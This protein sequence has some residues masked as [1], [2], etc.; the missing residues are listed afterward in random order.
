MQN[1]LVNADHAASASLVKQSHFFASLPTALLSDMADQFRLEEWQKGRY[2]NPDILLTR[3]HIL[4]DGQ[5]EIKKNNPDTGR[6]VMLDMLYPGD[7]F[8][9]ISL[10]DGQP[11]A[12]IMV[13]LH[14]LK[15]IS[16]PIEVMRQWLWTYPEFNRQFM[17]YLARKMR[18]QEEQAASFVLYDIATRLSRVI[19]K[20]INRNQTYTGSQDDAY[21]SHLISG[22]S[23]DMLARMVGSV[24]QVI[25]K[26][27]QHWKAQGILNK[28][29]NQLL[30]NDLEALQKEAKYTYERF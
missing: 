22:L 12:V 26:Q 10:L 23:D 25:N 6:E 11:H 1:S 2:I 9:V 28:K 13:P 16:A 4:L 29:R 30:I 27:L 19:L 24:R 18:E 15:L 3:F 17:P 20:H 14:A 7:S 21:K 5:L 8:D